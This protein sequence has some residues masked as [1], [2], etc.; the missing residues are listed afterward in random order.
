VTSQCAFGQLS[1]VHSRPAG[2]KEEGWTDNAK[3]I[4]PTKSSTGDNKI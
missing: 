2:G 3:T 4:S 1:V